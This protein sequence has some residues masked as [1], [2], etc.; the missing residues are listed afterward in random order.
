MA[1]FAIDH[2]DGL[3][4]AA[5]LFG[6]QRRQG[7]AFAQGRALAAVGQCRVALDFVQQRQLAQAPRRIASHAGEQRAQLSAE[8]LQRRRIEGIATA[9]E[10]QLQGFAR[11]HGKGQRIVRGLDLANRVDAQLGDGAAAQG[12]VHRV[13]LEYQQAVEQRLPGAA[14]PALHVIERHMGLLLQRQGLALQAAQPVAQRLVRR[15]CGDQRQGVDEQAE[16]AG[17]AGQVRRAAGHGRAATDRALPAVTLQ[18]QQP[19]ALHQGVE[20]QALGAGEV[21]QAAGGGGIQGDFHQLLP[22]SAVVTLGCQIGRR[23]QFGQPCFPERL[24]LRRVLPAQPGD[25]VAVAAGGIRLF[26]TDIERQPFLDQPRTAPAVQQQVVPGPDQPV[27]ALAEAQQGHALQRRAVEQE[28]R[29]ALGIGEDLQPG[30]VALA[31]VLFFP[32]QRQ[33]AVDQLQRRL[34]PFPGEAGAQDGMADD[35]AFPGGAQA[36]RVEI[37]EVEGQLVDVDAVLLGIQAVIEQALLHRR[38]RVDIL[39]GLARRRQ[40]VP[41]LGIELE[42]LGLLDVLRLAHDPRQAAHV[43]LLEDIPRADL[44]PRLAGAGDHLH[45][46][47]GVAAQ[48]E[49][50]V[51][52]ADLFDTQHLLPDAGQQRFRLA[53]RRDEGALGQL[54]F[55]QRL[56]VQLAVR[57]LRH[58]FQT[59]DQRRNHIVRQLRLQFFPQ[60]RQQFL[61]AIRHHI[62]DQLV[63]PRDHRRLAH[64]VVFQQA[65]FDLAQLDAEATNLHLLVDAAEVFQRAIGAPAHQ[66]AGAIQ[67]PAAA[68][69]IGDETLGGQFRTAVVTAGQT[70]AADIQLPGDT[71]RQRFQLLVQHMQR[72]V[73]QRLAEQNLRLL[74]IET[75]AGGPHRGFGGAIEIPHMPGDIDQRLRQI[76]RQC[77]TA[78]QHLTSC[79]FRQTR[80]AGEHAPG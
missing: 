56:A 32:G 40:A 54:R 26:L 3:R 62:A 20:G 24:A 12:G 61:A 5:H 33:L 27:L 16:H 37:V 72:S 69:R 73:R 71:G 2:R 17:A 19:G 41:L 35:Q 45:G 74:A 70:F 21:L 59:H 63:A 38:Q 11:V 57:R 53:L 34:Q 9:G 6:E 60:A 55:R 75:I 28:R 67:P 80:M 47:D 1:A 64:R 77:F 43:L 44:Q 18:E 31:P 29:I 4:R 50:V 13:V 79:Q 36:L 39:D 46:D 66:I 23:V 14:G 65:G 68:E 15:R 52:D 7:R 51:L 8:G 49:E 25:V 78:A 30:A 42:Y 58:L 10:Q 22:F 48:L 76:G